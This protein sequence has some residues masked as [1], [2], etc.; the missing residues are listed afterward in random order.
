M[1]IRSWLAKNNLEEF[2][3]AFELNEVGFADLGNLTH[4]D[5]RDGMGIVK[6]SRRK[7]ILHAIEVL[8][9]EQVFERQQVDYPE[10]L[11]AESMPTFLAHPWHSLIAEEHPR[12]K[13]HWLTDTAELAVRWAVSV[14]LAEVLVANERQLPKKLARLVRDD[15]ERP[16]LGRWLGILRELSKAGPKECK[17]APEVFGLYEAAF[18][19]RFESGNRGGTLE[20]SLLMLRNQIAHGG[21]MSPGHAKNLL[22]HHIEGIGDLLRAVLSATKDAQ[23]VALEHEEA[24]LLNGLDPSKITIPEA[25]VGV[26]DGTWLVCGD[27][28]VPLLPLAIYAPVRMINS[29]GELQD[30]PGGPVA[31]VF[32][33]AYHDRLSYTPLG[34]DEA[35]SEV[36]DVG[37]FRQVFRLDEQ[38][39]PKQFSLT[40]DGVAWDDAI[41]EARAVAED[42]I[43]RDTEVKHIKKWL[44]SRAPYEIEQPNVGWVS[45]G[46]GLGKSMIM[47]KMA[48]NYASGSQRGFYFHK[49]GSGNARNNRRTFLKLLEVALWAWEPL[50]KITKEPDSQ[51]DGDALIDAVQAR[52]EKISELEAPNPRAPKPSVWIFIDNFDE[53]VEHDPKFVDLIKKFAVPGTVWLL[54]GRAEHGLDDEFHDERSEHVFDGGLPVM[55]APDIRAMLLEGMGNA[56]YALLRRDEDDDE[57]VHNL[58]VERVVEQAKGLPLYVEL[59]L[60]DLRAGRITVEDDDKLPDGLSAYYD[61]LMERGG[62]STVSRDLPLLVSIL[63]RAEEPMSTE[64]LAYLLAPL[65]DDYDDYLARAIAAL[66]VGQSLLRASSTPDGD[67][68]Y[69]LYHQSF[70]EYLTGRPP[71]DDLP[72]TPPATIIAGTVREA[73]RLLY[74]TAAKWGQLPLGNLRNHLFRWGTTY[75]LELQGD[76]GVDE[77][78]ERL[79]SYPYLNARVESLQPSA[80]I[81]LA[82]EYTRLIRRIPDEELRHAVMLWESFFRERA[83]I[84]A[85]AETNWPPEKILMQLA[86][87]HADTSPVTAAAEAWMREG[88]GQDWLWLRKPTRPAKLKENFARR[89][90]AG[91]TDRI[92]G[93]ALLADNERLISW[94][95]DQRLKLWSMETGEEI[96]T[97]EGH[98]DSVD[99]A[100]LLPDNRAVSWARDGGL[101]LWDVALGELVHDL[102][103]HTKA[104]LGAASLEDGRLLS[105]SEDKSLKLWDLAKGEEIESMTG[106][107]RPLRGACLIPGER[108]LSWSD[109]KTLRVWSQRGGEAT[110]TLKGHTR[111][112]VGA[113]W[114]G[115]DRVVSWDMD[116][117]VRFWDLSTEAEIL[118]L[119]GHEDTPMGALA[120][121][122]GG[123]LTW[124]KDHSIRSWT[125][126]GEAV[127]TFKGHKDWVDGVMVL[128]EGRCLS[129]SKDKN[130]I[131]WDMKSGRPL[132]TLSGHSGWVRGVSK[133]RTGEILSW[134]GG[135]TLRI[136]RIR[137]TDEVEL[138]A[139]LEGHT[140]G[141]RGATE[142]ED[143]RLL[144][145]SWD[146]S[147]RL[148]EWER[149]DD[150]QET[151]GHRGWIHAHSRWDEQRAISWSSD[152]LAITW[153]LETGAVSRV[154][155]GHGKSVDGVLRLASGD[156]L[157]W[158]G[159]QTLRVWSDETGECLAEM[160]GHDKKIQGAR[161][162]SSGKILTWSSDG[163][164]KIWDAETGACA[165]A[166]EGHKK[167]VQGALELA[168][169]RI[170]SWSS[171]A[172]IKVWDAETGDVIHDLKD[173]KKLI[174]GLKLRADGMAVSWSSDKLIKLWDLDAG[175]ATMTFEGHKKLVEKL[176][177]LDDR[178]MVSSGKDFLT[179]VWDMVEGTQQCVIETPGESPD[180]ATLIDQDTLLAWFRKAKVFRVYSLADGEFI[181][182]V[183]FEQAIKSRADL[184]RARQKAGRFET[185]VGN[186]RAHG[187]AGGALIALDR[188]GDRAPAF[189]E[190]KSSGSWANMLL[191]ESG[192]ATVHANAYF[193][194]LNLYYG[195]ERVDLA[196]AEEILN[197]SGE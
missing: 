23:C 182:E 158:S 10:G 195:M 122:D 69:S 156:L 115:D 173:H 2:A 50:R 65:P 49:F 180:G 32:T 96:E 134:S 15:I 101:K 60:D 40:V 150:I 63:A 3:Q 1:S 37:F 133:L 54:C 132:E 22:D 118:A 197:S 175:E 24:H 172:T 192:V 91:H 58:F 130:L 157:T 12:V 111:E 114:L 193:H 82:S 85:R 191:D 11:D 92:E 144:S 138:L 56:R 66:R 129:W 174:K 80:V 189:V 123:Y 52:L 17:I 142:F 6:F 141:V 53:I 154:F 14:A 46:P 148:W 167:L 117:M 45:G 70:R 184:W 59:L 104:V 125:A 18:A 170:V 51:V 87:E 121:E 73:E 153:E 113:C 57:G 126:E 44:K 146:G 13:L 8:R 74:R 177:L 84:L 194:P 78:R 159:D 76:D 168:D 31:Q 35:H 100:M 183:S 165:V 64:A 137:E 20:N 147:M 136:W 19:P 164:V 152:A 72:G 151:V 196:R 120:L 169:G 98:D 95:I 140:A 81:D 61:G 178:R 4:E 143:G 48:A 162:L 145:W 179:I 94:S 41:K 135:G 39:D 67:A 90:F 112:V 188:D 62:L 86:I 108:V 128:R 176:R 30:R 88:G 190:W 119:E 160:E 127:K 5:L 33:R 29:S 186:W 16:T 42:L 116:N 34:R 71:K 97:L 105:W 55:S 185:S 103:G 110:S 21:G 181:E 47:A 25:L 28:V 131:L 7:E 27:E 89:V 187:G 109:D 77:A 93:A 79:T 9:G 166:L 38:L 83:H 155:E 149:E 26:E 75:A 43:G 124:G 163:K 36:L 106:H 102:A 171:D 107:T 139:V 99:G 161:Q 68:G